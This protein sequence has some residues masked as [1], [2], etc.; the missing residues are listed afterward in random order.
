MNSS[1]L[2]EKI[3][4]FPQITFPIRFAKL[5]DTDVIDFREAL[6]NCTDY[7]VC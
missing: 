7:V 1:T 2:C 6:D 5:S 4:C 3:I